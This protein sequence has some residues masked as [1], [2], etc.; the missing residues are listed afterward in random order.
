MTMN[1]R[2]ALRLSAMTL[3]LAS[4]SHLVAQATTGALSGRVTDSSGKPLARVRVS[5]DSPALF[6][7]RVL[8][9][10]AKGEYRGQLL[11]VGTYSMKL[12]ADGYV[13]KTVTDIRVGLGANLTFDFTLKG[14]AQAE[15]VVVVTDNMVTESK[16]E[17]K[18]AYNFS[19]EDLLKLPTSR[20]FDGALALAPGVLSDGGIAVSMRGGNY[21]NDNQRQGGGDATS[22]L[23]GGYNQVLYRIDGIDV[24]D[25]TGVQSDA[26][27]QSTLYQPLPDSIEDIQ[28][29]LS[30]LNAKNGRT[31]G[32]QVNIVTKTGGNE[33]HGSVRADI[34]R[35]SW[36]TGIP[37]GY[38]S[39]YLSRDLSLSE[40]NQANGYSRFVD[41]TLSGPIWKDRI[42]FYVGTRLQPQQ[43][44]VSTIYGNW[45]M[46]EVTYASGAPA[47]DLLSYP[48]ITGNYPITDAALVGGYAGSFPF[49]TG[50]GIINAGSGPMGN[51][52]GGQLAGYG[53]FNMRTMSDWGK[54]VPA[55]QAYHKLEGKLTGMINNDN[56]VF[57]T[58]LTDKATNGGRSGERSYGEQ[59]LFKQFM[60]NLVD[61]TGAYTVGWNG[62][63]KN[64]FIEA[65]LAR[66]RFEEADVVGPTTYPYAVKSQLSTGSFDRDHLLSV[67][68]WYNWSFTPFQVMRSAASDVP[69]RRGNDSATINIKTFQEWRGQHEIDF[70]A[71]GFTSIHGFGRER[72]GNAVFYNGGFIYNPSTQGFLFP[73]FYT[74]RP[75]SQ[76]HGLYPGDVGQ[77]GYTGSVPTFDGNSL[78]LAPDEY[79]MLGPG[80]HVVRYWA[81]GTEAKNKSQALWVNDTWSINDRWNVMLGLRFNK[82]SI[83]D[84]DG[85]E[86]ASLHILEPRLQVKWNPD[87]HDQHLFKLSAAKLAS[88]FSDDMASAFRTNAL[89]VYTLH[90]WKGLPGQ[91]AIDSSAVLSGGDPTGGVAWVDYS[92]LTNFANYGPALQI[93][94]SRSTYKPQGL[95]VPYAIEYTL[96]YTRNYDT[97]YVRINL[98]QRTYKQDWVSMIHDY[99]D[100]YTSLVTDPSGTSSGLD[101]YSQN[102]Y[103]LNSAFNRV[104]RSVEL[105]WSEAITSRLTFGGN[106]TIDS[107]T[108]INNFDYYNYRSL[109][110]QLRDQNGNPIPESTWAP[111]GTLARD[112]VVNAHLTYVQP[113]GKGNVSISILAKY[114]STGLQNLYGTSFLTKPDGSPLDFYGT[115]PS[116]TSATYIDAALGGSTTA[117]VWNNYLNAPGDFRYGADIY[118]VNLRLQG[119]MPVARKMMLTA[120]IQVD[121]LFNRILPT[122][123]ALNNWTDGRS[124]THA[125]PYI[126]GR[127]LAG[128]YAPWGTKDTFDYY[129]S[130]RTFSTLSVGLKF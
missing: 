43:T 47:V 66:A 114:T 44:G 6:Q 124:T 106:F 88:S 105:A 118:N 14:V 65:R 42:W 25:D 38:L 74:T 39:P 81:R 70:G 46:N 69:A 127:P 3:V 11:P 27:A 129:I 86:E 100:Q 97:G 9:T 93:A 4:G 126:A 48:M 24:K 62:T 83:Y 101:H 67:W 49:N 72:P 123:Q 53:P 37:K 51:Y 55:N 15:A 63:F 52:G 111:Q 85:S 22:A 103:F 112:R 56:T 128:F 64:W 95:K 121:N 119:Q 130:G 26:K 110:L 40:S 7:P 16:T 60:G 120:Y 91:N 2:I 87:G 54:T 19:A 94:D 116:G 59:T 41:V 77:F 125:N 92:Q 12:S 96:G 10:N 68:A 113:V 30:A 89:S 79:P 99:G 18:T 13:G 35:P 98:V 122:G 82:F 21:G 107:M 32:G 31:S 34:S 61:K 80:A 78:D 90:G 33:F 76:I 50:A 102:S 115:N 20:S 117:P 5:L 1:P 17:D 57:F 109:K 45:A 108:G 71:E 28:V 104:F 36:T 75:E 84:I 29:V 58:F 23:G 8:T 73:T